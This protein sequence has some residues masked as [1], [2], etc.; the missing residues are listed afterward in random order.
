M[1]EALDSQ[2]DTPITELLQRIAA[3]AA[4]AKQELY[5]HIYDD[6]RASAKRVMR[7]QPRN[8]FQTTDLV[9]EVILRFETKNTV[10]GFPNRRVLFSVAIRAMRQVLID[11]YRRRKKLI[12]SPDR[13]AEPLDRVLLAI[14]RKTGYDFE[15]LQMALDS[16]ETESPRLFAVI[17]SRVFGGLSIAETAKLLDISR[18]TVD[19]DW[20]LAKAKVFRFMKDNS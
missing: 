6:L 11:Q 1:S 13:V 8:D 7:Q 15:L 18:Q 4:E 5:R 3:G 20:K 14:E 19:R 12:D 16:L 10:A 9:N 17:N 2:E